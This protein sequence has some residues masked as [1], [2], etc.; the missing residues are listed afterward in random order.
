ML[1]FCGPCEVGYHAGRHTRQRLIATVCSR[2]RAV[3]DP[4]FTAFGGRPLA[5]G[6]HVV[7]HLE[8]LQ[9]EACHVP[10]E[11][12]ADYVREIDEARFAG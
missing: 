1:G 6:A 4:V 7:A 5:F 12:V 10:P 3:G 8:E 11:A 9:A 2:L